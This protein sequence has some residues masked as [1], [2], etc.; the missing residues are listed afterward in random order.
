MG[1]ILCIPVITL[2]LKAKSMLN[3]CLSDQTIC[4]GSCY[5]RLDAFISSLTPSERSNVQGQAAFLS[6]CL[7]SCDSTAVKCSHKGSMLYVGCGVLGVCALIICL[8]GHLFAA[9]KQR[10]LESEKVLRKEAAIQRLFQGLSGKVRPKS[11]ESVVSTSDGDAVICP[12]CTA[13]FL[14]QRA[15]HFRTGLS[16][17]A[18]VYCIRCHKIIAGIL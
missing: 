2:V 13:N 17:S 15:K 1:L 7:E 9:H 11:A 4:D 18:S 8:A 14:S 10:S 3:Q 12:F 5:S 16:P 6:S